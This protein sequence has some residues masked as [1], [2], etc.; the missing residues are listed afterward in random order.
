MPGKLK[1]LLLRYDPPGVGLEVDDGGQLDVRHKDLPPAD[2]VT[3][4]SAIHKLVDAMIENEPDLLTKRRHRPTLR[5]LLARLYQVSLEEPGDSEDH[6]TEKKKKEAPREPADGPESA[7]APDDSALREGRQVVVIRQKGKHQ[8]RNGEIGVIQAGPDSRSKYDVVLNDGHGGH[9]PTTLRVKGAENLVPTA[10]KASLVVG[11][12]VIIRGLRNHPELNGCLGRVAESHEE[13]HRFE[14]RAAESGQLFRVKRENLVPIDP[15]YNMPMDQYGDA[16]RQRKHDPHGIG[17]SPPERDG[18][19]PS[20]SFPQVDNTS[21]EVIEPGSSVQLMGLKSAA[22]FNGHIAEIL[23][24]DRVRNRY[25]IRMND[26]SV[27]TIR[28]MN[29]RFVSGP[30]SKTTPR[31]RHARQQN[32]KSTDRGWGS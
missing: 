11:T 16:H 24:V 25:E 30:P 28:A 18:Q 7:P 19:L 29:V 17:N 22:N 15:S 3:T 1:R 12:P 20:T 6:E 23:S 14:V 31:T 4:A 2:Q 13:S 21:G 26:G 10:A 8:I 27:K 32:G 5:E 9:E